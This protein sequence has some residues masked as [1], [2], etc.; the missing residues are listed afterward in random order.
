MNQL[1]LGESD[2]GATF[3]DDRAYR[4]RLWRQ[5][6][7]DPGTACWIMLNPSTA[8]EVKLDPTVR[9]CVSF[10][11]AW[12]YGRLEV[13]NLFALRATDPH[14]MLAAQ[15][16]VGIDNNAEIFRTAT[17][18]QIVVC[19][20]G[21]HGLHLKRGQQVRQ[22]LYDMHLN[23]VTL[24]FTKATGQP[25]HPLYIRSDTKPKRWGDL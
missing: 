10:T 24:G 5:L 22:L 15:L 18:S 13:V 8:D 6:S 1:L 17:R 21:A 11:R 3:S 16:P 7:K 14:A 4:Y 20:W 19:A 12:G 2:Q 9:R 23:I 25:R